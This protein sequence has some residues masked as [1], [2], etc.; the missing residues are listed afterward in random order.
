MTNGFQINQNWIRKKIGEVE[1][2]DHGTIAVLI[3]H[4]ELKTI[5]KNNKSFYILWS[6]CISLKTS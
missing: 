5:I 1:E 3:E 4:Q 6:S 2:D